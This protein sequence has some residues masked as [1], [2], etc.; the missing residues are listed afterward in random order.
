MEAFAETPFMRDPVTDAGLARRDLLRGS[1]GLA[2]IA[3]LCCSSPELPGGSLRFE[4]TRLKIN[5]RRAPELERP[6]MAAA[7]VDAGRKL[8]LIVVRVDK[9]EFIALDRTCT[10]GGAMCTYN[11][12]R[13]TL[14]CTSLNHAEYDLSGI[15][16][17]GRSHGNLRRYET[18]L[19]DSELEVLV[20]APA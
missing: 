6:G 9:R 15:L 8:N 1:L 17:H 14:R 12:P 11:H 7:V 18:R 4:G 10:H 20:G 16:L 2:G 3:P 19:N 5:L 13:K